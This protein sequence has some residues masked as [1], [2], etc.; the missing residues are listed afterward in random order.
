MN[1]RFAPA[2]QGQGVGY[3][4]P[5]QGSQAVGMGQQIYDGYK[6]ARAVFHDIDMALGRPL[7]KL[8]FNGPE[9]KLRETV[10]AQPAIMAVSLASYNAMKEALGDEV[11]PWPSIMAGHSLGEY[12]ALAI[13]GVLDIADTARLVQERGRLMQEACNYAPGR[14]AAILG[15]DEIT[16][17]EIARETGTFVSN[18]NT[19]EQIVISGNA[20]SLAHALDMAVARGAKKAIPL[21]VAGAFHSALM[22]PARKG[23]ID[24][25]QSLKFND[26]TVPIVGNYTAEPLK[27]GDD[28]KNE[29]ISQIC[30]C[31][32][33]N[34]SMQYMLLSGVARFYEIGPGKVLSGMLKR[35]DKSV[36][37]YSVGDVNEILSLQR[38]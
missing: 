10:N 12:T 11:M 5:G 14:M 23:L 20:I 13:A 31:V 38:N 1:A 18:I 34:K 26:P 21:N 25:V 22:E 6:S 36:E 32:Q 7:S 16:V 27:S 8:L 2:T 28:I 37:A 4:F 30:G 24:A 9:D 35:I 33:W 19:A 3:L 17:A 29:L 15:L